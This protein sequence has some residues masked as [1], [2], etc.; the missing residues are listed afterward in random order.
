MKT[1]LL[2]VTFL[3]LSFSATLP[4]LGSGETD[5]DY[6][7]LYSS[8]DKFIQIWSDHEIDRQRCEAI[9]ERV[10]KA[11]TFDSEQEHWSDQKVLFQNPLR[12]RVV[13]SIKS[14][15]LG[16][17]LGKDV[18]VVRDNYLDDELSEGTLAHELTHIQDARQLKGGKIP[19]FIAEGR[20]LTN[21]HN[22][23]MS[24]GQKD[25][26]Y[27]YQMASS[28]LKYSSADADTILGEFYDTGWDME[29]IGTFLVEYMRTKWHGTGIPNVHPQLSRMIEHIST[30]VDA[31]AAFAH[32]FG[33]PFSELQ[34]SF[35]KYLDDTKQ[36]PAVRLQGTIW[37]SL[38]A[39]GPSDDA[40]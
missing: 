18:F 33:K 24:L 27:D 35:M 2:L 23:R 32:Q 13:S 7:M 39:D 36:D 17:A 40:E 38:K 8:G 29:A 19:S 25:N 1:I 20:A 30:G 6:K 11:Y 37:A 4:S 28:A 14:K 3:C 9:A 34:A 21:G 16:Y 22:Y 10:R 5:E 31:E 12:V 15:I 26:K